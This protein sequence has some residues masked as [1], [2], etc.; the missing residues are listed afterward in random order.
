MEGYI[1]R[2]SKNRG[3]FEVNES[4][5]IEVLFCIAISS[6]D[7]LRDDIDKIFNEDK[8]ACIENYKK[9]T[10]YNRTFVTSLGYVHEK[11]A[12]K[13]IGIVGMCKERNDYTPLISLYKKRYKR[14]Y[15][16]LKNLKTITIL[17][18]YKYISDTTEGNGEMASS[19]YIF[20]ILGKMQ[21]IEHGYS[22]IKEIERQYCVLDIYEEIN[23]SEETLSKN[24]EAINDIK[25]RFGIKNKSNY[26]LYD[27]LQ[28]ITEE[29]CKNYKTKNNKEIDVYNC[30]IIGEVG[31]YIGFNESFFKY[32][33][34]NT[35]EL[36]RNTIFSRKE[37]DE[38]LYNYLLVCKEDKD[39]ISK[40]DLNQMIISMFYTTALNKEYK[41]LKQSY[42]KDVNEDYLLEMD[43]LQKNIKSKVSELENTTESLKQKEDFI[44][45]R[46]IEYEQAL[47]TKDK[48]ISKLRNDL[49][50]Y[51]SL[52]EEVSKLRELVFNLENYNNIEDDEYII[53]YDNLN[54]L[55][56]T[57]IGGSIPWIKK[58][59]EVLPNW[60]FINSDQKN[61]SLEFIK[62]SS[63]VIINTNMS[64]ALYYKAMN[65]I[66]K[67]NLN[68]EYIVPCSNV[69][70]TI[71]NIAEILKT[72]N[73]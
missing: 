11:Y 20:N 60:S 18:I 44:E 27:L 43:A 59:K 30:E 21:D 10:A 62:N 40:K 58:M 45:K 24:K 73:I 64:H 63:L 42:S 23:F 13:M 28:D 2:L 12:T 69:S 67:Y 54:Q 47:L 9:S 5:L 66:K 16:N 50:D 51:D 71:Y 35:D 1:A 52:R 22:L 41:N 8:V 33:K 29:D 57:V 31:R 34:I 25:K 46:K 3:L 17:D 61:V 68:Y 6:K 14:I 38:I 32:L 48:E 15:S 4:E 39:T 53:D 37:I 70:K 72:K 49:K 65:I 55:N 19:I 7:F 36:S 56:I 26:S